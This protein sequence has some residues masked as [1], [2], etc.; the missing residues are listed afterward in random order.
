ML[1]TG[2]GS[3]TIRFPRDARAAVLN[4]TCFRGRSVKARFDCNGRVFDGDMPIGRSQLTLEKHD[5]IS[6]LTFD[7]ESW[8]PA[9]ELQSSDSRRLGLHLESITFVKS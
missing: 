5:D 7:I 9:E 8:S 4:L 6:K 3:L 2:T 1:L